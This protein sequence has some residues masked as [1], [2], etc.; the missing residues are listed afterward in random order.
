MIFLTLFTVAD[1]LYVSNYVINKNDERK[2]QEISK[3][4][5]DTLTVDVNSKN[6]QAT[7]S[8][9]IAQTVV[10]TVVS[11]PNPASDRLQL[12]SDPFVDCKNGFSIK[13][14]KGWIINDKKLDGVA[15]NFP[16]IFSAYGK[17]E[18]TI[19]SISIFKMPISKDMESR[20]FTLPANTFMGGINGA[21]LRNDEIVDIEGKQAR[22]IEYFVP[23][24]NHITF[25][26]IYMANG[27]LYI[28]SSHTKTSVWDEYKDTI[29]E[30]LS[31]FTLLQ[32]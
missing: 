8:T 6:N 32:N 17:K 31:S 16:V 26:L 5:F 23:A 14:P 3:V 29:K 24:A 13:V 28:S 22:L 20:F 4:A 30:S 25:Q 18:N 19:T 1:I 7:A 15:K 27:S 12:E 10:T 9:S 21:V 11:K 2:Q